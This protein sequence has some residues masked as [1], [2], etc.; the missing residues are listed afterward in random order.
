MKR[1]RSFRFYTDDT[2]TPL[3][4]HESGYL[5]GRKPVV[6]SFLVNRPR[7]HAGTKAAGNR[8]GKRF[9][10]RLKENGLC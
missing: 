3:L 8:M 2:L 6:F 7:K 5:V 9:A 4:N 1:T 10:D